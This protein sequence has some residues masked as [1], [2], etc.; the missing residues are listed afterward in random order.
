MDRRSWEFWTKLDS[1][2]I[3]NT[4]HCLVPAQMCVSFL[5]FP[6]FTWRS[7]TWDVTLDADGLELHSDVGDEGNL[8]S[9]LIVQPPRWAV[10]ILNISATQT[11]SNTYLLL[12]WEL[13]D[14]QRLLQLKI[15][16]K[17]F[18]FSIYWFLLDSFLL[19]L[20]VFFSRDRIIHK[21][22]VTSCVLSFWK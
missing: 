15:C 12:W 11:N 7:S 19:N 5:E 10:N 1:F 9:F 13:T 16:R 22:K 18:F 17:C 2:W 14:G 3:R 21:L 20:F 4:R 6:A 8:L